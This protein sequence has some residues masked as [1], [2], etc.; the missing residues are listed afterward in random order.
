[1]K[2]IANKSNKKLIFPDYDFAIDANEIKN[3]NDN[4]AEKLLNNS[5]IIEVIL[6]VKKGRRK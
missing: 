3:V 1:M 4:L 6:K 2:K 5:N